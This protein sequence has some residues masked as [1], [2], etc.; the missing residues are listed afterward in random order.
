MNRYTQLFIVCAL[1]VACHG[2][3]DG[4]PCD[5]QKKKESSTLSRTQQQPKNLVAIAERIIKKRRLELEVLRNSPPLP[6]SV[7]SN[8]IHVVAG[9]YTQELNVRIGGKIKSQEEALPQALEFLWQDDKEKLI[10]AV[11]ALRPFQ[12]AL[13]GTEVIDR[14]IQLYRNTVSPKETIDFF[15][16]K[17]EGDSLDLKLGII[18]T[19]SASKDR[20][21]DEVLGDA[22][23]DINET[24]RKLVK[25]LKSGKP[26]SP[27]FRDANDRVP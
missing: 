5:P 15:L 18:L 17:D 6:A 20:R 19:I 26:C 7:D 27:H 24:V 11:D 13:A 3:N 22:E 21:M 8:V 23:R 2:E 14:L 16:S 4:D 1:A 10:E 9:V 25:I 12:T